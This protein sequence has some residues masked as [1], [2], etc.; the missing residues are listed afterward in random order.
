MKKILLLTTE[1]LGNGHNSASGTLKAAL[2]RKGHQVMTIDLLAKANNVSNVIIT[3]WYQK[4]TAYLPWLYG[5]SYKLNNNEFICKYIFDNFLYLSCR[6]KFIKIANQFQPDEVILAHPMYIAVSSI[7]LKKAAKPY[8]QVVLVTD[9]EHHKMYINQLKKVQ[10]YV[11]GSDHTKRKMIE[12]GVAASKIFV[13]GIPISDKFAKYYKTHNKKSINKTKRILVSAGGMGLPKLKKVVASLA[14]Q[15]D[16]NIKVI[17]GNNKKLKQQLTVK[18][19]NNKLI[20]ILGFVDNMPE[21]MSEADLFVSKPGGLSTT[22]AL[23]MRLPMVI[24]F[25]I[26]G[27]EGENKDFLVENDLAVYVKD[28]Q[29]ISQE[30]KQLLDDPKRLAKITKNIDNLAKKYSLD[31]TIELIEK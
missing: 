9:F 10:A 14:E 13:Y 12:D 1:G 31:K 3:N 4:S 29:Q 30:V 20:E 26:P 7:C 24:P 28:N 18:Y 16:Y 2:E 25:Y 15:T 17:C 23:T 27:Q 11:V 6:K 21:L 22:E 19:Q 8:K 5:A